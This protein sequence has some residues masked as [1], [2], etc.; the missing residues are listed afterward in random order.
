MILQPVASPITFPSMGDGSWKLKTWNT[1]NLQAAQQ[2]RKC[3]LLVGLLLSAT[4]RCHLGCPLLLIG[5]LLVPRMS[6]SSPG[7]YVLERTRAFCQFQ[8]LPETLS[9]S[10]FS[11]LPCK[12]ECSVSLRTFYYSIC[13]PCEHP[14]S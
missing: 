10:V 13:Y 8:G 7:L 6:L 1:M 12:V 3:P 4:F 11:K 14:A 5:S 9:T 2:I